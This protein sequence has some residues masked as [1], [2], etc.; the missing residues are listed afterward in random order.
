MAVTK[1]NGGTQ[2]QALTITNN[3]V[4]AAAGILTTKLADGPNFILRTGTVAFTAPQSMGGNKLTN[5]AQGTAATDA[6]NKSQLDAAVTGLDWKN[7]CRAATT[8]PLTLA[9][10]FA[11]GS[12]IDGVTLVTGDRIL[13]KDQAA[14]SEN[15]IYTVN[16]SGA[17]TRAVD[18]DDN[19]D[20]TA[21]MATF[22]SEGTVNSNSQW[23]LSTNDPIVVGTTPL[24]FNQIGGATT[25]TG[26]NGI[27][28]AGNVISPV[29]GSAANTV[30]QGNDSRLTDS[31]SPVGTALTSANIFVGSAGNLAAAVLMSGDVTL[32]N[33]G[34]ATVANQVKLTKLIVRETP[35][36]TIN[37][38]NTAFTIINTPVLGS[39]CV[40]LNGI[41]Q[42]AGAGN[43]YT[44]SGSAITMLAAPLSG[45]KIRVNYVSQ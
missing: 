39:E 21:G 8:A 44:I 1:I 3:E 36:G 32:S 29:Y 22:V 27:T 45:D 16:A 42:D 25:Y 13:I 33:T 26:S 23:V 19:P 15:G 31:R 9:T 17:P 18:A 40:F 5:V 12:V 6:V 10:A 24:V 20:V 41:L 14:G 11:N 30:C 2:I 28:V 7:S 34:V 37:G 38:S 43:D 4:A 35:S